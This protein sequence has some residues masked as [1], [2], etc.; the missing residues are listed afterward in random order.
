MF[1]KAGLFAKINIQSSPALALLL[2]DGET[3]ADLLGLG[4]EVYYVFTCLHPYLTPR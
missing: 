3:L 2:E 1:S 4:P